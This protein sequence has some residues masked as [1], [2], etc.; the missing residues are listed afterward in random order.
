MNTIM[1]IIIIW[2]V[3]GKTKTE[4]IKREKQTEES[5]KL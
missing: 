5:F 4:I 2:Q 1:I 3:K